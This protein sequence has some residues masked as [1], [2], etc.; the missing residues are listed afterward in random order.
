LGFQALIKKGILYIEDYCDRE[1]I[2]DD[3]RGE[4]EEKDFLGGPGAYAVYADAV[5]EG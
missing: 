5:L 1:R 2:S 4:E 3:I